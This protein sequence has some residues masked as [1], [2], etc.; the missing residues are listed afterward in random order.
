MPRVDEAM[1]K[2]FVS[3]IVGIRSD[4]EDQLTKMVQNA[5]FN[6]ID[7][8]FSPITIETPLLGKRINYSVLVYF[9]ETIDEVS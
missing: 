6:I 2:K 9:E 3:I 4:V 1:K 8:Q 7:M 5:A